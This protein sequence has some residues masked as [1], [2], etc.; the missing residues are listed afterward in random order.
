MSVIQEIRRWVKSQN[1][2]KL[3]I[4]ESRFHLTVTYGD[5]MHPVYRG[6]HLH[7]MSASKYFVRRGTLSNLKQWYVA[8]R[9]GRQ[10]IHHTLR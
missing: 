4:T 3:K 8:V 5:E 1:D 10:T 6:L 7:Q 2:P 9:K